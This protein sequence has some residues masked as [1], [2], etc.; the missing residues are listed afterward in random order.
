MPDPTQGTEPLNST[1]STRDCPDCPCLF[2]VVLLSHFQLKS[3]E[4]IWKCTVS[5]P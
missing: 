3:G 2:I 4:N 5:V 1:L